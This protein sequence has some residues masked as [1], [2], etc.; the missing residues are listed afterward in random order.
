MQK[1]IGRDHKS[2]IEREEAFV[3]A[4]L[5]SG[6]LSEAGRQ[7]GASPQLAYSMYNR[8]RVQEQIS[9]RLKTILGT[10]RSV[11]LQTLL[12][13]AKDAN[14]SQSAS[15]AA[16]RT[17]AEI[18]GYIGPRALPAKDK[19]PADMNTEEL[20]ALVARLETELGS[21]AKP[22]SPPNDDQLIDLM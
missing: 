14:G 16:A 13:V 9:F 10:A 5:D 2:V 3:E 18:V 7:V 6:S 4:F 8:P 17:L 1:V 11:C 22:V 21:R 19:D 20:H 15:V 12:R